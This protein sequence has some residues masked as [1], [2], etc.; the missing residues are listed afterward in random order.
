[1]VAYAFSKR[2]SSYSM[3]E[4][5]IDWKSHLLVE[6]SNNK[7]SCDLMN[8]KIQDDRNRIIDDIIYYKG[9]S[10]LVLQAFHD[11]S[12]VGNHGFLKAYR[13]TIE[14]FAWKG[15]KWDVMGHIKECIIFQ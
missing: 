15:L 13:K 14:R 3:T 8:G 7:F 10:Y 12:L 4:I 2:P 9:I 11:S 1:V 6:Y 5:S